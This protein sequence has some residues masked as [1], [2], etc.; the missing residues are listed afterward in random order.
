MDKAVA[1]ASAHVAAADESKFFIFSVIRFALAKDCATDPD[2]VAPS[3]S[4]FEVV[5]HAHGE[6]A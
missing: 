5:G 1:S 6:F 3:R 2:D 4:R